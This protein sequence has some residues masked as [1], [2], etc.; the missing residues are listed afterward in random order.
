MY[1]YARS[2]VDESV[3]TRHMPALT[4]LLR[5]D[6][7]IKACVMPSE[8][9]QELQDSTPMWNL[10]LKATKFRDTVNNVVVT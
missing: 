9:G 7:Q 1:S 5:G 2:V 4:P 6:Q 3:I 10:T 8:I